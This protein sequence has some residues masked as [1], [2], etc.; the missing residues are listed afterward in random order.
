MANSWVRNTLAVLVL[1]GF[2]A[3]FLLVKESERSEGLQYVDLA[4]QRALAE[5]GA[6]GNSAVPP[7]LE[8]LEPDA[9][10]APRSEFSIP[11]LRRSVRGRAVDASG[12]PLAGIGVQRTHAFLSEA[13]TESDAEGRFELTLE[14]PQGELTASGS[15][16]ILIGGERYLAA[17]RE[18]DYLLVLAPAVEFRGRLIDARGAPVSDASLYAIPPGDA[19]VRFGLVAPPLEHESQRGW[20]DLDGSFRIGPLPFLPGGR[21]EVSAPGSSP[22]EFPQPTDPSQPIELVIGER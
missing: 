3:Y 22:V 19:L 14:E 6:A 10:A 13:R 17:E 7:P 2:G 1:L 18:D 20:S 9:E 16:W 15:G 4:A 21:I 5:R 8:P 12:N 11:S